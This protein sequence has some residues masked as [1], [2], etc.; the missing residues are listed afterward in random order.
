[1][2][3]FREQI[4]RD[5]LGCGVKTSCDFGRIWQS[6]KVIGDRVC[7]HKKSAMDLYNLFHARASLHKRIYTHDKSKALEYMVR[8][9]FVAADP[10]LR[11]SD[12]IH[13]PQEFWRLTDCVLKDIELSRDPELGK[14]QDIVKRLRQRKLYRCV[15]SLAVPSERLREHSRVTVDEILARNAGQP[16]KLR[17]DD[18]IVH[19]MEINYGLKDRHG[20]SINPVDSCDFFEDWSSNDKFR[21]D[22]DE[23]STLL[24]PQNFCEKRVR[25]F[26]RSSDEAV[27]A[28]I[29][30]AVQQVWKERKYDC[31]MAG[32]IKRKRSRVSTSSEHLL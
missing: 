22:K 31:T 23:V 21:I 8:D 17:E 9:A 19:N 4:E 16:V 24:V 5:S 26:S 30:D 11:M 14:A 6:S 25:V 3:Y 29:F 28:A 7:F 10:I 20:N 12:Q 32:G 2:D 15:A 13:D 1:V 18:I 27:H